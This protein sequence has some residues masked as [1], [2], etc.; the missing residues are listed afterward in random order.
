MDCRTARYLLDFARPGTNDLDAADRAALEGHL[1]VCQECDSFARAERRLDEHIGEAIRDVPVPSGLKDRLLARLRRQREEWWMEGMKRVARYAAVAAAILLVVWGGWRTTQRPPQPT[2]EELVD[3][4]LTRHVHSLPSKEE[5][6]KELGVPLPDG[7]DY[8]YLAEYGH[9]KLMGREV[10]FLR[11]VRSSDQ[12]SVA[13]YAVVYLM[14]DKKFNLSEMPAQHRDPGGYR[15]KVAIRKP[16][17]NYAYAIVYTG[18][19]NELLDDL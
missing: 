4:M 1:A 11:F 10:P 13:Q 8:R 19:L 2:G 14:T 6:E 18:D 12:S 5:A 17:A 7:L 15:F 3:F 9:T 16:S